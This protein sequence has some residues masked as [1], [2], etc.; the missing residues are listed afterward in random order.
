[1]AAITGLDMIRMLKSRHAHLALQGDTPTMMHLVLQGRYFILFVIILVPIHPQS[2]A[3]NTSIENQSFAQQMRI[4]TPTDVGLVGIRLKSSRMDLIIP[5]NTCRCMDT[6]WIM[7]ID[8][9]MVLVIIKVIPK[10]YTLVV[11]TIVITVGFGIRLQYNV[12]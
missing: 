10:D 1:M 8:V 5:T 4:I 2:R 11:I 6:I 12:Q 7:T 3:D 9:V